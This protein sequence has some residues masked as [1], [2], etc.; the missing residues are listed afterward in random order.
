MRVFLDKL[1][2]QWVEGQLLGNSVRVN[3]NQYPEMYRLAQ[4]CA[5]ILAVPK[6]PKI[7]ITQ[8]APFS[9][10]NSV[11][12]GTNEDPVLALDSFVAGRASP[13]ELRFLIGREMGHIKC[14]HPL[15]LTVGELSRNL[16]SA[17]VGFGVLGSLIDG[18]P[19]GM[20][21]SIVINMPFKAL[22]NA[23]NRAAHYTADKAGLL[24]VR[25]LDVAKTIFAKTVSSWIFKDLFGKVNFDELLSQAEDLED[26]I[27]KYSEYA[28]DMQV[29]PLGAPREYNP[30]YATPFAVKRLQAL[31]DYVDTPEYRYAEKRIN[32]LLKGEVLPLEGSAVEAESSFC[33]H[34][35][36]RIP[37]GSTICD[38]C[39]AL[40]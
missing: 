14:G 38:Q 6:M 30:G 9:T 40:P 17:A 39:G 37:K 15:Y 5:M 33:V 34:C 19:G 26:T 27:G 2:T 18:I 10:G 25:K 21:G 12:I 4:E 16:A 11:S 36:N 31:V 8:K 20:L 24:V 28:P 29:G 3:E 1:G 32:S 23:W 7:Y 13:D 35:G 22:M